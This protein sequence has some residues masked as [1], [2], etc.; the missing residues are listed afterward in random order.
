MGRVARIAGG[1]PPALRFRHLIHAINHGRLLDLSE[2]Q[3]RLVQSLL[4]LATIEAGLDHRGTLDLAAIA[5]RMARTAEGTGPR[6]GGGKPRAGEGD[7]PGAEGNSPRGQ[8]GNRS[9]GS[10][11]DPR[12]RLPGPPDW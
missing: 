10:R 9:R 4:T 8:C 5:E 11:E 7:G 12:G 3:G 6:V 2:Q 1:E